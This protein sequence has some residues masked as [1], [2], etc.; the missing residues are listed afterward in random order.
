MNCCSKILFYKSL[1]SPHVDYCSTILFLFSDAQLNEIQKIQ[2]RSMRLILKMD[3]RTH[4][5][6]MLD[7]LQWLSIK[8]RI[9][10]NTLKFIHRI[11][12]GE[13]PLGLQRQLTL[14]HNAHT[15]NLR[16]NN[17]YQLNNCRTSFA[18]NSLLHNGLRIYNEFKKANAQQFAQWSNKKIRKEIINYVKIKFTRE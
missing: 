13:V 11:V 4:I 10:A 6:D 2:N 7:M 5:N 3:N 17:E 8:Q 9:Y 16:N 18:Q 14:R 12:N 1:I 15:H